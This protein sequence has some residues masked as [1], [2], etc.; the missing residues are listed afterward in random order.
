MG[1]GLVTGKYVNGDDDGFCMILLY[2]FS[3][4]LDLSD[5]FITYGTF[6][7]HLQLKREI[8]KINYLK[9]SR[10]KTLP[11]ILEGWK[12]QMMFTSWSWNLLGLSFAFSGLLTLYVDNQSEEYDPSEISSFPYMKWAPRISILLFE[13]AAPAAMLVSVVV[14]YVLWPKA[15]AGHGSENLIG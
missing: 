15:L 11:I 10:L 7:S 14:K 8:L 9:G 6:S 5:T 2:S 4:F 1:F 12:N 13:T 3:V